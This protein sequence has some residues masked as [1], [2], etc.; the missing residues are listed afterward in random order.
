MSIN[1]L[2]E[3]S[4][5]P[6]VSFC[7]DIGH[8]SLERANFTTSIY[9]ILDSQAS[10]VFTTKWANKIAISSANIVTV[11]SVTYINIEYDL[12][13]TIVKGVSLDWMPWLVLQ[14]CDAQVLHTFSLKSGHL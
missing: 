9:E 13:Q 2:G 4:F 3:K 5:I 12:Q 1:I 14:D 8:Q 6:F 7:R 11:N 10:V